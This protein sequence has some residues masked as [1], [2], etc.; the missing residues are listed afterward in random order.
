[1]GGG[2]KLTWWT[3]QQKMRE[4][5]SIDKLLDYSGQLDIQVQSSALDVQAH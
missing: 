5:A 4:P 3:V 2:S 1:M